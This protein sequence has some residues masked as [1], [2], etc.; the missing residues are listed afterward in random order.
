SGKPR[1][2]IPVLRGAGDRHHHEKRAVGLLVH[3]DHQVLWRIAHLDD[4]A[5]ASHDEVG[6]DP[7]LAAHHDAAGLAEELV[8][9]G[10][11]RLAEERA[12]AARDFDLQAVLVGKRQAHAGGFLPAAIGSEKLERQRWLLLRAAAFSTVAVGPLEATAV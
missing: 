6:G 2:A 1:E 4:D 11:E 8:P 12:L 10:A 9:L 7:A 3:L 5:L